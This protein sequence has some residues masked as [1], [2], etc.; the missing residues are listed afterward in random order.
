MEPQR[1]YPFLRETYRRLSEREAQGEKLTLAERAM[2]SI[3]R[4]RET[5]AIRETE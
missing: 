5:P 3:L 1:E 4:D 2:L